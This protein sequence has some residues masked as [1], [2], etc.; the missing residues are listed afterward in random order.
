MSLVYPIPKVS[1]TWWLA[2][3]NSP[4]A[5]RNIT[6]PLSNVCAD[7]H[8]ASCDERS[9]DPSRNCPWWGAGG[10]SLSFY[11]CHFADSMRKGGCKSFLN[12]WIYYERPKIIL[13]H[14]GLPFNLLK[15][16]IT[17]YVICRVCAIIEK[18]IAISVMYCVNASWFIKMLLRLRESH[19]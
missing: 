7:V 6:F 19:S 1:L 3:E 4:K 10:V 8:T 16:L 18:N 11:L 2:N 5:F 12:Q 14:V 9:Q 17:W 13:T 15:R